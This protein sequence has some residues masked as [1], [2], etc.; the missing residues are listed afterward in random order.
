LKGKADLEVQVE[1]P[2]PFWLTPKPILEATGNA[3]LKSV[4]VSVKQRLM[5]QLLSDYRRWASNETQ[6]ISIDLP[7][8]LSLEG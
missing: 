5:S 2:P 4:L 6:V 1:L 8:I 7:Q 3:L